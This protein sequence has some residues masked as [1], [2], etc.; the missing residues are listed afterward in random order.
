[1]LFVLHGELRRPG[2]HALKSF[3]T[4]AE[5][6]GCLA[7]FSASGVDCSDVMCF[8]SYIA[9]D[10]EHLIADKRQLLVELAGVSSSCH[11]YDFKLFMSSSVF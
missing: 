7:E 5:G 6:K 11:V 2:L 1:M 9:A 3:G 8:A 10:D 4:I